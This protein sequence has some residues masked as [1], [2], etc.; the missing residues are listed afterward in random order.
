MKLA[1]V[2]FGLSFA[3]AACSFKSGKGADKDGKQ[4]L[5]VSSPNVESPS[6]KL[7]EKE[8]EAVLG[9]VEKARFDYSTTERIFSVI[10]LALAFQRCSPEATASHFEEFVIREGY[11]VKTVGLEVGRRQSNHESQK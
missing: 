6:Q 4:P 8:E 10:H 2:F 9:C 3:V 1:L 11:E 5:A 7:T